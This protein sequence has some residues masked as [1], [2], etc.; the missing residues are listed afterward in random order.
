MEMDW[1]NSEEGYTVR[2][3]ALKESSIIVIA[4]YRHKLS[5]TTFRWQRAMN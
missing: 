4:S 1:S 2:Y 5:L 3:V